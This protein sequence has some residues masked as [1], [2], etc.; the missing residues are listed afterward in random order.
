MRGSV[1]P[2]K[3]TRLAHPAIHSALELGVTARGELAELSLQTHPGNVETAGKH[4]KS[5][6]VW[7]L[8]L[9][10][11]VYNG[12]EELR[13]NKFPAGVGCYFYSSKH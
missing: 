13:L 3:N 5:K 2:T 1:L 8:E 11:L 7:E 9:I 12:R 4:E 6:P 10:A